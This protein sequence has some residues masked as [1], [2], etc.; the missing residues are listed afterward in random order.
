MRIVSRSHDELAAIDQQ[1]RPRF[2]GKLPGM[3]KKSF[4]RRNF[5][6]GFGEK[7]ETDLN[8]LIQGMISCDPLL[9][10]PELCTFFGVK[11]M[12]QPAALAQP[13]GQAASGATKEY[14]LDPGHGLAVPPKAAAA[15]GS[16]T[17]AA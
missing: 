16:T 9:V 11:G 3:P 8:S 1:I 4:F 12:D 6:P 15:G 14:R 2:P 13:V 10:D 17:A 7:L 5:M